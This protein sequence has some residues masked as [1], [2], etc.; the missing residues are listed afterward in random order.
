MTETRAEK[1]RALQGKLLPW[2][3]KSTN[4]MMAAQIV[5]AL[6]TAVTVLLYGDNA[7]ADA[8]S[9]TAIYQ[10]AAGAITGIWGALFTV[11]AGI[12]GIT[13]YMLG[14]K[15][16]SHLLVFVVVGLAP[17]ILM[18]VISWLFPSLSGITVQPT[19]S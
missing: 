18:M 8:S 19:N 4:I 9:A 10:A 13:E 12:I 1:A 14:G 11:V 15:N 5:L 3:N 16:L 2:L 7:Y 17:H 6:A